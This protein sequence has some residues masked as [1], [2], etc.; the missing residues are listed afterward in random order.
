[1]TEAELLADAFERVRQGV[2]QVVVGLDAAELALRLDPVANSVA[3]LIWHTSRVQDHH[4]SEVA[5][6]PQAYIADGFADAFGL[7]AEPS[8]IGYG[9]TSDQ[10]AMVRPDGAA[11]LLE[12]HD[13]VTRR[14]LA[15]VATM[16]DQ[17]LNRIVDDSYDPSVSLGVRLV[18]VLN[19]NMQHVG[20]AK[21]VR[22]LIERAGL[23]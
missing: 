18:S 2:N 1:M 7:P 12:Y 6:V 19:D 23:T 5:S 3:W 15:Y 8:D 13:A 17:E 9:H 21:Y 20:Q 22:G 10:V 11:I 16:D 14:T 4:I